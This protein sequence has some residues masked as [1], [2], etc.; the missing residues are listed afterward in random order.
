L[1]SIVDLFGLYNIFLDMGKDLGIEELPEFFQRPG[2]A[3]PE[4]ESPLNKH[5]RNRRAIPGGVRYCR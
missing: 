4:K 2:L 1:A 3:D 5:F